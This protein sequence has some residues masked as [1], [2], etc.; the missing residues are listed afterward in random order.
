MEKF[1]GFT[2]KATWTIS[3]WINNDEYLNSYWQDQI[4][5]DPDPYELSEAL[6]DFFTGENYPFE[7]ASVHA[8]L[9]DWALALVNWD[10][11]A[12]NLLET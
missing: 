9:L 10:E 3:L 4:K 2:N 5:H 7:S 1:E 12:K 11:I 6:K 8:D